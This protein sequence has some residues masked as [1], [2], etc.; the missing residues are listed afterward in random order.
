[1]ENM[2][3]VTDRSYVLVKRFTRKLIKLSMIREK[4]MKQ[5]R[6]RTNNKDLWKKKS[7]FFE[8]PYWKDMLVRHN[9]DVMHIEKNICDSIISTLLDVKGKSKDGLNSHRDLESMCIRKEL[10]PETRGNIFYL[11]AASH[12]LS[13]VEK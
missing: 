8:L 5:K 2:K 10:H 4:N 12:T 9:L 1:M 13:N 11:P 6:K 7:I 3:K